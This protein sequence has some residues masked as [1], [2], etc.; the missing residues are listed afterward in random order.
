MS[1]LSV[2]LIWELTRRDYTERYA[3]SM[4]GAL[5][6][7]IWPLV[8]LFIYIIVFGK[9]MGGRL[10]GRSDIYAYSIYVSA[11]L[12]PW[13]T[14]SNCIVRGTNVFLEKKDI[15]SKVRMSLPSLLVFINLSETVT[16]LI[17]MC[18]FFA[19][20]FLVSY[21]FSY[22]LFLVPIV[23]YL[24]QLLAFALGLLAATLIVFIRDLREVVNIILQLWF[25]F[26]PLVYVVEIVPDFL[27]KIMLF[28]PAYII[29]ESY[30]RMFVFQDHPSFR[31]LLILTL[32]THGI[33]VLSYLCFRTLEKDVRDFL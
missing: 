17:T 12:I 13:L 3:G 10:P 31:S 23:F 11:G 8:P 16:Y 29:T 24:Q 30:H 19:F 4:L 28:N 7:L 1:A 9:L 20:L 5:W 2:S 26:T 15:I 33:L 14:F 22:Y 25:W 32:I 27:K 21:D 18:F 6:A